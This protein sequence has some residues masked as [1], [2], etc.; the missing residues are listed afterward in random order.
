MNLFP[1][2]VVGMPPKITSKQGDM[3]VSS[4][5]L[6]DGANLVL[7][8]EAT[9]DPTPSIAWFMDGNPVPTEFVMSDGRLVRNVTDG[10]G[11]SRAGTTYYCTATNSIGS[12][13][14]LPATVRSRDIIVTYTCECI[15]RHGGIYYLA[16]RMRSKGSSDCSWRPLYGIYISAKI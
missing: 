11:A 14:S 1:L 13:N 15:G 3:I 4:D 8:C 12:G 2:P 10:F 6:V 9:G 5:A 16:P 7:S